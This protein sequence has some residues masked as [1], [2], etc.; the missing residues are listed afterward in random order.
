LTKSPHFIIRP[1]LVLVDMIWARHY[2]IIVIIYLLNM[3]TGNS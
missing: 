2:I 3:I 1:T